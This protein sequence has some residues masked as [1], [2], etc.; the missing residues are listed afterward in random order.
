VPRGTSP[1]AF[2]IPFF[3]LF[4]FIEL[5]LA[6]LA[7]RRVFRLNDAFGDLGCGIFQQTLGL[8]YIGLLQGAHAAVHDRFALVSLEGPWAWVIGIV[9]V[10]FLYYWWHRAS[11]RVNALWAAHVVHHQSEDMNLA[12]ALRQ[13][14]LT[15]FTS[16]PFYLPLSLF[17]PPFIVGISAAINTLYQFWIHTDLIPKLG[18]I[19]WV[20]N[21]PSHHRGHHGINPRY[22]DKNYGGIS[23][24]WD[25]LF[26]TFALETETVVYGTVEPLR[27]FNPIWAQIQ[28]WVKLARTAWTTPRVWDKVLVWLAPPE[29][30]PAGMPYHVAPPVTPESRP[31]W[32]FPLTSEVKLAVRGL[33]ALAV[34]A[35]F[36]LL[37]YK[38]SLSLA[39]L[40][41]G[42]GLVIA[43]LLAGSVLIE[44]SK[45]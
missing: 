9:G 1:I 5:G 40:G 32:D 30:A 19:E 6:R 29:W 41:V 17:V 10:D 7:R 8:F 18:P 35:T 31:K 22:I 43:T 37:L 27:S 28:P 13:A 25:R 21:T 15:S 34:T 14:P 33:L 26:G 12:V 4:I 38:E 3:F 39:E 16:L 11:H 42:A 20:F 44:R 2:A 24:I 36:L 23:I 45:K